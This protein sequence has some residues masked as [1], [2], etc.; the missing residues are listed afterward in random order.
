MLCVNLRLIVMQLN[1]DRFDVAIMGTRIVGSTL[2]AILASQGLRVILFESKS[3][4]RFAI[5]ESMTLEI[6][7]MM[8]SLSE[9]Y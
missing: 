7:E 9:I 8:R 1:A 6:S 4:P 2:G 5:G 3:H